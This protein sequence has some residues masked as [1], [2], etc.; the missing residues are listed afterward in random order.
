MPDWT[1]TKLNV[2]GKKQDCLSLISLCTN[3]E[4]GIPFDLNKIIPMP[5]E[6]E[7]T[8]NPSV[9]TEERKKELAEKYR[10]TNWYSWQS[11]Y[12]GTK[13]G[14]NVIS[15]WDTETEDPI[16]H[17][18]IISFSSPWNCPMPVLLKLSKLFPDV[19][20]YVFYCD[21]GGDKVHSASLISGKI[22]KETTY[23]VESPEGADVLEY[24]NQ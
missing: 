7:H 20:L 11:Y 4:K 24:I 9:D 12:W 23:S 14:V 10:F 18:S 17:S 15:G 19:R 21:E 1:K 6:L 2:T 13:W 8:E 22:T 5:E 16:V 3:E